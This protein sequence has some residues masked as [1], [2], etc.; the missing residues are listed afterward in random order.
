MTSKTKS[1]SM[2]YQ[3]RIELLD[4]QPK[5]WRQVQVPS[6]YN[7]FDLHG[8]LNDAMVKLS[9]IIDERFMLYVT[10][11]CLGLDRLSLSRVQST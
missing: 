10:S 3:F 8:A 7:M 2:I 1:K 5:I 6:T 4:T 11:L 9:K